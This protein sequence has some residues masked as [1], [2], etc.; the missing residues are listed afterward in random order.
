MEKVLRLMYYAALLKLLVSLGNHRLIVKEFC[1]VYRRETNVDW[2][3]KPIPYTANDM[4]L[5]SCSGKPVRNSVEQPPFVAIAIAAL[6]CG[7][8][9]IPVVVDI[10]WAR[11]YGEK[12]AAMRFNHDTDHRVRKQSA[13]FGME[14]MKSKNDWNASMDDVWRNSIGDF[15][16]QS[17]THDCQII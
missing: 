17:I 2:R 1:P 14:R 4:F 12:E 6:D 15:L 9:V 13:D 11:L 16:N 7:S 10:G 8:C 5:K 3:P